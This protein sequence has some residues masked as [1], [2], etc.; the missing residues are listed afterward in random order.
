MIWYK[1]KAEDDPYYTLWTSAEWLFPFENEDKLTF[2]KIV[3][4][5]PINICQ[6]N[7]LY[8]STRLMD[9]KTGSMSIEV[10]TKIADECAAN[11]ASIRYGG[12]GEPLL[13]KEIVKFVEICKSRNVRTTIFTNASLLTEDM[14]RTFCECGLDEIR[15]SSAGVTAEQHND[16]RRKSDYNRD[17]R[18]KI[19]MA[20]EIKEKM[21]S[22]RPYLSLYTV[23]FDYDKPEFKDNVEGYVSFFLNYADKVDIDLIDLTKV[24]DIDE[25]RPYYP[26][27]T[28]EEVYKPCVTLY[29]KTIVHWNGD[30]FACDIPYNFEDTFY[31]GNLVQGDSI[32]EGYASEKMKNLRKKTQNLEHQSLPLCKYCYQNTYKYEELKKQMKS[33][34]KEVQER[35]CTNK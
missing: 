11:G 27:T 7:C 17:L 35:H 6:N 3:T 13:H 14:M 30:F 22:V 15:F 18:D 21:R 10:M 34:K 8:C 26:K 31:L 28:I 2:P 9:R 12:F 32:K 20:A 33:A 1:T 19:I 29:H 4:V 24:R 23:V 25:I 5:E 16:V